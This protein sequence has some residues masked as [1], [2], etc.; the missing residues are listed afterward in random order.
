MFVSCLLGVNQDSQSA[1]VQAYRYIVTKTDPEQ[2]SWL[3]VLIF[4]IFLFV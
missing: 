4:Y 3:T 2:I 1:W